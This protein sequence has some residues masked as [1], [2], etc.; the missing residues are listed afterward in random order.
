MDDISLSTS[1][2]ETVVNTL[3]EGQFEFPNGTKLVSTVHDVSVSELHVEPQRLEIQH[4]VKLKTQAE[5]NCLHF[6]RAPSSP[7][8]LPYLFTLIEGGQFDP[9][10]RHGVIDI[11]SSCL[12][13]I[14]AKPMQQFQESTFKPGKTIFV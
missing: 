13:A 6:V 1:R 8:T 2:T 9:G 7:T 3:I 10:N 5:A 4:C 11:E 14:V 12:V